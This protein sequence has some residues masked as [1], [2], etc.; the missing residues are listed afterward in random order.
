MLLN[1]AYTHLCI[2]EYQYQKGSTYYIHPGARCSLVPVERL[3]YIHAVPYTDFTLLEYILRFSLL[4]F[5]S[6]TPSGSSSFSNFITVSLI[7]SLALYIHEIVIL[8][9]FTIILN[10]SRNT[11]QILLYPR[12][13]SDDLSSIL[14]EFLTCYSTVCTV[15][16]PE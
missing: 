1:C 6:A 14:R 5:L 3:H 9:L 13:D 7:I 10:L 2:H 16:L 8:Y 12:C 4:F 15:H 11:F